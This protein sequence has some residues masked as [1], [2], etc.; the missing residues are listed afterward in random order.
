VALDLDS[1]RAA[2]R[3]FQ[4]QN[5]TVDLDQQTRLAIESA[6]NL[7]VALAADEISLKVKQQSLSESHPEVVNLQRKI[8][9]TKSQISALEYGGSDSSYLNLPVAQ[10]PS[11]KIRLAELSSRLQVSETLYQILSEQLEQAKIQERRDTPT[12][13]V[14]DKAYPPELAYRPQKRMIV[15]V[16]TGT[17]LILAVFLALFMNYLDNLKINNPEE[18]SRAQYF[19]R[20][21]FGWIPGLRK[22]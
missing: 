2:L 3:A 19:F 8:N 22:K 12:L 7:K 14:L 4:A 9:E 10:V 16:S 13:S 21:I 11:L 1:A 15:T 5:K 18:Y 6:V 20:V 17:A